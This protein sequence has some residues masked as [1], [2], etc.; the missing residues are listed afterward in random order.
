MHTEAELR[1]WFQEVVLPERDVWV[2]DDGGAVV[3]VLC[4]RTTG[5][6]S[7]TSNQATPAVASV[8]SCWLSPSGGGSQHRLWTFE[9]NVRAR[10]FYDRHG[11]AATGATAG[12]NEEG[13]PDVRYEWSP[14]APAP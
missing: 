8:P 12:D 1:A 11:F 13:A 14:S 5:S 4:S 2:A 7:S 3:A 6:I 10:S 9:A